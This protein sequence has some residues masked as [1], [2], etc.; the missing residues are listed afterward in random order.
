MEG[1][2]VFRRSPLCTRAEARVD[3]DEEGRHSQIIIL[4]RGSN[5]VQIKSLESCY[6]K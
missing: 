6:T 4:M 5:E 3:S 1:V 2:H